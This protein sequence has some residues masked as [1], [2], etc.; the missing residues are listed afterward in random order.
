M[1]SL[2]ERYKDLCQESKEIRFKIQ[3]AL[4]RIG[5]RVVE[6][7]KDKPKF[8]NTYLEFKYSLGSDDDSYDDCIDI[9]FFTAETDELLVKKHLWV[10][11][12]EGDSFDWKVGIDTLSP[13]ILDELGI[14]KEYM[15][16]IEAI[17]QEG[18]CV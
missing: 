7:G 18:L 15:K 5:E 17:Y 10:N 11:S 4:E 14:V 13:D 9:E 2:V 6:L 3:E 8:S 1:A 16:K 12:I